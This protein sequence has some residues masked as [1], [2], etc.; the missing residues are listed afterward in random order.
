LKTVGEQGSRRHE[1]KKKKNVDRICD[2]VEGGRMSI[3]MQ[4]NFEVILA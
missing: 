2:Y 4:K 3:V 1:R